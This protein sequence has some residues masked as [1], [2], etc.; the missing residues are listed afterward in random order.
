M[1]VLE[2]RWGKPALLFIV[3][4]FFLAIPR[5][6]LTFLGSTYLVELLVQS[7][8]YG[9]LALSLNLLLGYMGFP[10]LAHGAY[11]GIGAYTTAIC[12]IKFHMGALPASILAILLTTF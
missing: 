1:S 5:I 7:M 12:I 8:V 2:K 9:I 4:L 6:A 11:L 3:F 10:S